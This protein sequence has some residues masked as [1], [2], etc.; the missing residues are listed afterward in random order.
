MSAAN[1][2]LAWSVQRFDVFLSYNSRDHVVVERIARRLRRAGFEPWLDRWS[3]TPGRVWH[4]ELGAGLDASAACAVFVGADDFGPWELEELAVALDRSARQRDFRVFAVLLPSVGEPFDPNGLPHF[5][6]TRMWVDF[7]RGGNDERALQDLISAIKGVPF[8]PSVPIALKDDAAPYRGLLAFGEE[9]ARF[10]FGRDREVQR[11]LEKLK[12]SRFVAVLGPS[13]S[14]KSS[15]VRAGLVPELRAGALTDG[16]QW[17]VLGLRPGAAPLTALAAQLTALQ[18]R[19]AMQ[20]TLDEL[21]R[22]SRT[23]HLS[24]ELALA[25][26]PR[27]QRVLVVVDQLEEVFTLCRDECERGQLLSTLA[28]AASVP[29]GRTVVV[30]ALRADFYVRC[31]DYPD[32]AQLISARQMLVGPMGADELRQAIQEPARRVGLELEEG[33]SDT[34]LADVSAQ[35]GALPLLE[36]ALLEL[37]ERRRGGML[38]L[39]GY[40][41]AGG[42]WEALARR[43]DNVF[44]QLTAD[45]QQ[46]AR[47]TLLRLTQPGEGTE[48][49]RRRA[50]RAELTPAGDSDN[51]DEVLE[52]L[53]DARLLTTGRDETGLE[54]VDVSHEALIRGWP[55]LRG[56]IDADRAGLLVH[57]RLTDAA[58]QWE[59]LNREP[60]SLYRGARLAAGH[61]WA[62]D[63]IDDLSQLEH[64]F[65]IASHANERTEVQAVRRRKTLRLRDLAGGLSLLGIAL[66]VLIVAITSQR[67]AAST[68]SRSQE[69][70]SLANELEKSLMSIEGGLYRYLATEDRDYL[71]SVRRELVAYPAA[72]RRLTDLL[73][74]DP[75]RQR[76]VDAIDKAL[77]QY[78]ALSSILLTL[79]RREDDDFAKTRDLV[80]TT[81]GQQ[82]LDA[83]RAQFARLFDRERALIRARVSHAYDRSKFAIGWAVGGLILVVIVI[84]GLTMYLLSGRLRIR[85]S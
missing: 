44:D 68:V 50:T 26:R 76:R 47:R 24:V 57:R 54:I 65:L 52:R 6:R 82:R 17:Q 33:L 69:A 43:A 64:D 41:E 81:V 79:T 39:E 66:V 80:A 55:R 84:L 85:R 67:D 29:G 9:D 14:G 59:N 74:D 2:P 46:L 51:F 20:A 7:R 49:T 12:S 77:A 4:Q 78:D 30:V 72:S 83:A 32:L 13:G 56:W 15:L 38:T 37:W 31:A 71:A 53:V 62:T 42:V 58:Q 8:G 10:F 19:Q 1:T 5:L 21:G 22:D 16:E 40:R 70:L 35:P 25:D 27:D 23:L 45:R 48:D 36:H 61:E 34:I 75:G 18:P 3:L 73:S 63:H 11:L 60:G 28:Y